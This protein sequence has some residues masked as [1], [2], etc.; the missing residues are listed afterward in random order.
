MTEPTTPMA[1]HL[2]T[3]AKREFI[4]GLEAIF[5]SVYELLAVETQARAQERKRLRAV[6][7]EDHPG[8]DVDCLTCSILADP[9]PEP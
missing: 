6:H 4:P 9:E 5:T 1:I 2:V 7:A 8:F 3:Y